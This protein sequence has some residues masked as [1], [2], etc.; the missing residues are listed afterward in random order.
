MCCLRQCSPELPAVNPQ[1]STVNVLPMPHAIR[2]HAYG[3]PEVMKWETVDV[4]DPG[5]GEARIRHTAIGLN[6]IDVY[7]RT[8][9]YP[10]KLPAILG[11]EAA[12]VVEAVGSGVK[13]LSVGDRVAY[14]AG[15]SGS[16]SEVRNATAERLVRIP[17]AIDDRTAAAMMLKG[18]T[19]QILLRQ[20]HR[21]REGDVLLIHAAA[22]GV[23]LIAVQWARH[24]GATVIAV[25]GSKPKADLVR[26]QGAHHVLM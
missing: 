12:G 26:A 19:A 16:Y 18:L 5:P 8:G 17:D 20:T 10:L 11:R 4:G 21:V 1:P 15:N 7:E 3:G 24:L 23:G 6:Y 2:I 22:G 9:L 25:V 14:T 13:H